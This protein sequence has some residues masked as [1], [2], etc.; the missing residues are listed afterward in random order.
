[1]LHSPRWCSS[2]RQPGESSAALLCVISAITRPSGTSAALQR[3]S[4]CQG[5]AACVQ[6]AAW[7]A[8]VGGTVSGPI[9]SSTS[10]CVRH[11]SLRQ[12]RLGQ[13]LLPLLLQQ[14]QQRGKDMLLFDM[15]AVC[16]FKACVHHGQCPVQVVAIGSCSLD[17]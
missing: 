7:C 3:C 1:M 15:I 8:T 5:L 12:R 14:H 2:C 10:A 17:R 13:S 11:R 4:W 16:P 6:G 9:G